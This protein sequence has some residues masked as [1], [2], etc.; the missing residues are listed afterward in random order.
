MIVS[1]TAEVIPIRMQICSVNVR[2]FY[3]ILEVE[4]QSV[5]LDTKQI[6]CFVSVEPNIKTSLCVQR[7]QFIGKRYHDGK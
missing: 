6:L 3:Q 1:V 4:I 2:F 5:P 7:N